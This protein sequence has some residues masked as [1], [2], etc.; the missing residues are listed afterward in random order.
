M[1]AP[2]EAAPASTASQRGAPRVSE[3]ILGKATSP[4]AAPLAAEAA[5]LV[6]PEAGKTSMTA[7]CGAIRSPSLLY[8]AARKRRKATTARKVPTATLAP[9][10]SKVDPHA[11]FFI[12][13]MNKVAAL[14]VAE[15]NAKKP[16]PAGVVQDEAGTS[17]DQ[18][19][20]TPALWN[21]APRW[22][23]GALFYSMREL[24]EA[25]FH[26]ATCGTQEAEELLDAWVADFQPQLGGRAHARSMILGRTT[27][28]P[29]SPYVQRMVSEPL[30]T[31]QRL[32]QSRT[33]CEAL[34]SLLARR[35]AV[36]LACCKLRARQR[37]HRRNHARRVYVRRAP[38]HAVRAETL[39]RRARTAVKEYKRAFRAYQQLRVVSPPCATLAAA[40]ARLAVA[41][42][43]RAA[44]SKARK[45]AKARAREMA[46]EGQSSKATRGRRALRIAQRNAVQSQL[47]RYLWSIA[48]RP[49]STTQFFVKTLMGKTI[50]IEAAPSDTIW[51]VKGRIQHKEGAFPFC[52]CSRAGKRGARGEGGPWPFIP[53]D[54]QNVKVSEGPPSLDVST[55]PSAF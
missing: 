14:E 7:A 16:Q 53:G 39:E 54:P 40:S 24:Q 26:L 44:S 47:L 8:G 11:D 36:P 12:S 6:S 32:V 19:V 49:S 5:S 27:G 9:A 20:P 55:T 25:F 3:V 29:V 10:P 2:S 21:S 48:L 23:R 17:K 41:A 13:L 46:C 28:E 38:I 50:T 31:R 33:T 45:V 51:A 52:E 4:T 18:L 30:C 35:S 43:K 42:K 22:Y 15:R 1:T 37:K 34:R